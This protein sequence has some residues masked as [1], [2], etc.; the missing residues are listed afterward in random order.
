MRTSHQT[1]FRFWGWNTQGD[2][3]PYTFYTKTNN[4]LTFYLRAPPHKPANERQR[5][6][7]QLLTDAAHAWTAATPETRA[8]WELATKRAYLRING[9]NLWIFHQLTHDDAAIRTIERQTGLTLLP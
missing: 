3:G 1:I 5:R 8:T 2:F 6:Q 9:C 7:R 4:A